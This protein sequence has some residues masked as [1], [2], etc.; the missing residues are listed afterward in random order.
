M[1]FRHVVGDGH[2]QPF[3]VPV[4]RTCY[5]MLSLVA[6]RL[7]SVYC[8]ACSGVIRAFC[9]CGAWR[10]RQRNVVAVLKR[11]G[12]ATATGRLS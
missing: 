12:F 1:H 2:A 5:A 8:R 4:H 6:L 11:M 7:C 3:G 10:A 9:I